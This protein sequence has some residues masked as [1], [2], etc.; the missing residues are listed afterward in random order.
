M[1]TFIN[2]KVLVLW[3]FLVN[4]RE[5]QPPLS[6]GFYTPGWPLE[7]FNNGIVTSVTTLAASL[8]SKGHHVSIIASQL[9]EGFTDDEVY[10]IQRILTAGGN[11]RRAINKF[12][13]RLAPMAA[14][15]HQVSRAIST[16]IRLAIAERD[17]QVIEIEETFGWAAL[18]REQSA[19]PVC[20]RLHGPWFLNGSA[21]G[22][23]DD[24]E[25]RERVRAEGRGIGTAD[26]VSAPSRNVL[27]KVREYYGLELPEAQVIPAPTAPVPVADRW[28]LEN[29][30]RAQVAFIG[31]FDRHKGGDL[32]IEAFAHVLAVVP[33][34][35][36]LFVGPDRG[37][38]TDD[39]QRWSIENFIRDR[40]PGALESGSVQWMGN[41][42]LPFDQLDQ[43]RQGAMVSVIC[44]R[45]ENFPL[46]VVEA[47]A[48]GCPTIA[49]NAGGIGEI[50]VDGVNGLLHRSEDPSDIAAKIIH[51]LKNPDDAANLGRQAAADC[52][53]QFYPDVVT[54]R[55]VEFYR[56]VID[57]RASLSGNQ[58]L[59]ITRRQR[60]IP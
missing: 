28:R 4:P 21:L 46:T 22:L 25:F 47:M 17:L 23:A 26:G 14:F 30:N 3:T 12:W 41:K 53:R 9:A 55:L 59:A 37:V 36:L 45:Y 44:S 39:G 52:E 2:K 42:L 27:E 20:I 11:V 43:I 7:A 58:G 13:Y 60:A 8:K 6:I 15:N 56:T 10:D 57:R 48:R 35:R 49:A 18:V 19:I 50:V 51:V 54:D 16:M 1:S 32:I 31:R 38:L 24:R 29:R 5:A 40:L 33:E 34:A